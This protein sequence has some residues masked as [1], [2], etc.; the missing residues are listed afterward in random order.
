MR[1]FGQQLT[2]A[3]LNSRIQEELAELVDLDNKSWFYLGFRASASQGKRKLVLQ[4]TDVDVAQIEDIAVFRDAHPGGVYLGHRGQ[5]FR[6]VGYRGRFKIGKWTDPRSDIVLGKFIHA[7]EAIEVVE[8]KRRTVTRGRWKDE[9]DLYLEK[10]LPSD[11][12]PP[13][14][15]VVEYGIWNF[16][17]RFDGY[18]EIDLTGRDPVKLVTLQE[19]SKRFKTALAAGDDF[20]SCM[21]SL[22]VRSVGA[23]SWP[24]S[25]RARSDAGSSPELS[26]A[27]FTP[28]CAMRSSVPR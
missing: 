9:F 13:Q 1:Y 12:T 10:D 15:G 7:L 2:I 25:C 26:R 16:L 17:R 21:L 20:P 8:E 18:T 6:V 24:E 27:C 23:G 14:T 28:T 19:V 4:G 5:R 11:A 3:E 22:I